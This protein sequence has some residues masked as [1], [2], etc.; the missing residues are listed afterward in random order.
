MRLKIKVK[1]SNHLVYLKYG[2]RAVFVF[3]SYKSSFVIHCL[4]ICNSLS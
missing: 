3:T 1:I 2:L 4:T